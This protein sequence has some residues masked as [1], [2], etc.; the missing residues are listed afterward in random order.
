ME[1]LPHPM[2]FAE[3]FEGWCRECGCSPGDPAFKMSL[4]V[5]FENFLRLH[6]EHMAA[7]HS[8]LADSVK[9]LSLIHD[10]RTVPCLTISGRSSESGV[11]RTERASRQFADAVCSDGSSRSLNPFCKT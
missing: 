7:V 1:S 9:G 10:S 2:E 3:H 5:S 6:L 11:Q 4:S 8:Q